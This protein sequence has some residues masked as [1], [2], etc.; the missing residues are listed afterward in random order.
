MDDIVAGAF[1]VFIIV[2]ILY[3][4]FA[5]HRLKSKRKAAG[6]KTS[7]FT[8]DNAAIADHINSLPSSVRLVLLAL[9]I[10][11]IGGVFT[12]ALLHP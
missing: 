7:F 3:T 10:L 8:S 12:Y 6:L 4:L 2:V 1:L 11:F 9:L 5:F